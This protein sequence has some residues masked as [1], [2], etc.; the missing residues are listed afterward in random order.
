MRNGKRNGLFA[1]LCVATGVLLAWLL[2]RTTLSGIAR[3]LLR[4]ALIA[5]ILLAVLTAVVIFFA[6]R[7]AK[8][9]TAP[10]AAQKPAPTKVQKE[11]LSEA[12]SE[13]LQS[14][15]LTARIRN[16]QIR[17]HCTPILESVD[18]IF[19]A[20]EEQPEDISR[21]RTFFNYYLPTLG[22][23]LRKYEYLERSS[24]LRED[25]TQKVLDCLDQIAHAM[26]RQYENLFE[27]DLIDMTAEM[28]T[29][30]AICRRDGLLMNETPEREIFL[31]QE[32]T[33]KEA[34]KDG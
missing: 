23:I 2:S 8:D 1:V 16:S 5:V 15:S 29:L 30:R 13:L 21:L 25:T 28:Q 22:N 14:R 7:G 27:D 12:K 20:L 19:R 24:A 31:T 17:A 18:R 32:T 4:L 10:K 34:E 33:E 9:S 26:Q 3:M 6:L 11:I